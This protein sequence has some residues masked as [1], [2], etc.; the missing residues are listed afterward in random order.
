MSKGEKNKYDT[1][2]CNHVLL[3][4]DIK[5]NKKHDEK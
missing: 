2:R 4:L 3:F 5:T 1:Q